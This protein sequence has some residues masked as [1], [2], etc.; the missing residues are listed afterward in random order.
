MATIRELLQYETECRKAQKWCIF[1]GP[2][3][4]DKGVEVQ[5][6]LKSF[7]MYNQLFKIGENQTNHASGHSID[8]VKTMHNFLAEKINA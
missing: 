8:K 1:T 5:V 2:V 4:N 6:Q 3:T 7:G